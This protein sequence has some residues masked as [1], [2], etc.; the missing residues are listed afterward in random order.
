MDGLSS[1]SL[2]F[3][4]APPPA[5]KSSETPEAKVERLERDGENEAVRL[6]SVRQPAF[7]AWLKTAIGEIRAKMVEMRA[8]G[9]SPYE[10]NRT[11][12]GLIKSLQQ[13]K[14]RFLEQNAQFEQGKIAAQARQSTVQGNIEK[15]RFLRLNTAEL[16]QCIRLQD[17]DAPGAV[18]ACAAL[19]NPKELQELAPRV[20]VGHGMTTLA[21]PLA[22]VSAV[23]KGLYAEGVTRGCM[24]L[25]PFQPKKYNQCVTEWLGP[26]E[27]T[28]QKHQNLQ[29]VLS[30]W[31]LRVDTFLNRLEEKLE[32]FDQRMQKQFFTS[33]GVIRE[34]GHGIIGMGGVGVGSVVFKTAKKGMQALA[35]R[36]SV[37]AAT[38]E[39]TLEA[40]RY[41]KMVTE[42]FEWQGP[43]IPKEINAHHILKEGL[44]EH[45]GSV[46]EFVGRTIAGPI[47]I[48]TVENV[49]N[50][51]LHH[52]IRTPEGKPIAFLKET[53]FT[54]GTTRGFIPE[55]V[56]QEILQ[57]ERFTQF[58]HPNLVAMGICG[59]KGLL[60]YPF[61]KGK[62]VSALLEGG[63]KVPAERIGRI[64]G[65][66]NRVGIEGTVS[67][68]YLEEK[69]S[70]FRFYTDMAL[71]HC[72]QSKLSHRLSKK[73]F[74]TLERDLRR[75]PGTPGLVHGDA[76][77]N[78]LIIKGRK[79]ALID[80]GSLLE[81]VNRIGVPQ[82]LPAMD[83]QQMIVN[84]RHLGAKYGIPVTK[85]E[86]Q[87]IAFLKGY[88]EF[89]PH[90]HTPAATRFAEVFWELMAMTEPN[91]TPHLVNSS[92]NRIHAVLDLP[93]RAIR[94]RPLRVLPL[95]LQPPLLPFP[96]AKMLRRMPLE[97]LHKLWDVNHA[98]LLQLIAQ[99]P[100]PPFGL[101]ATS[102]LG[103]RG[104]Q[105]AKSSRSQYSHSSL[106][107]A[108]VTPNGSP[109]TRLADL[110]TMMDKVSEYMQERGALVL[111]DL[112]RAKIDF[113]E[114]IG[115]A[116]ILK[117][118]SPAHRRFFQLM[119]RETDQHV[120]EYLLSLTPKNYDASVK[121]IIPQS[122]LLYRTALETKTPHT[123]L[124]ARIRQQ[125]LLLQILEKLKVLPPG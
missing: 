32:A 3:S 103:A 66:L 33:P 45:Y 102:Y 38:Q 24:Q 43:R 78:N 54:F 4:L 25:H 125:A 20:I 37:Q 69:I 73:L 72:D 109:A 64:F 65:E 120:F 63:K 31:I 36:K 77:P 13:S 52:L 86:K 92:L 114:I 70:L 56:S 85:T 111:V 82:G 18:L 34:A 96:S 58:A 108:G 104:I 97:D 62:A 47:Q 81:S 40:H 2:G 87:V 122:E 95:P 100:V 90:L 124:R 1:Y 22:A 21:L 118:D 101:H 55:I 8:L 19:A 110:Y 80:N 27:R 112:K 5:W 48:R 93:N 49:K 42:W 15:A 76:Y 123:L 113:E 83:Q 50:G 121:A 99:N 119:E 26:Q 115:I 79:I 53:L 67:K 91:A 11:I 60:L 17:P 107:V 29:N 105:I 46:E 98:Q 116:P 9:K 88:H 30:R 84:L 51:N 41:T 14:S 7:S 117:K 68:K 75:M 23:F 94:P 12:D 71:H 6:G 61:L 35:V 39:T 106:Y 74:E 44:I 16:V 89:Y 59:E 28:P 10:I 57:I